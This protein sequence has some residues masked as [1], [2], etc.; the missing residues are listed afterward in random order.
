MNLIHKKDKAFKLCLFFSF[1]I[2]SSSFLSSC[3]QTFPTFPPSASCDFVIPEPPD[4]DCYKNKANTGEKIKLFI[5]IRAT[6]AHTE[7]LGNVTRYESG[8]NQITVT[9]ILGPA[10][11]F[12]IHLPVD[13]PSDGS[14][15]EVEVSIV[16]QECSTCA[17][18]YSDPTETPYGNCPPVTITN[19]NPWTYRAAKPRW[20]QTYPLGAY[21]T[22]QTVSPSRTFNVPNSCGCAV[23]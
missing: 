3:V 14:P 13:I 16:G 19:T 9:P 17:N 20:N 18:G 8:K 7:P 5:S 6:F 10:T 23:Q 22:T 21:Y 4:F 1:L 11:I 2:S 15:Y 12:P